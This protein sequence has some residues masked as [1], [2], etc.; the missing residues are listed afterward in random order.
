MN[1]L[2]W[3]SGH[4]KEENNYGGSSPKTVAVARVT[5]EPIDPQFI[6]C[7]NNERKIGPTEKTRD[8]FLE[9]LF[10]PSG[11]VVQ[12]GT[13]SI[14]I[15]PHDASRIRLGPNSICRFRSSRDR[16]YRFAPLSLNRVIIIQA[17]E[18]PETEARCS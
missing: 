6:P 15:G 9:I 8:K 2:K 1:P 13:R 18:P 12:T 17:F 10:K 11:V 7:T 16:E 14:S 4:I 3:Y 5:T